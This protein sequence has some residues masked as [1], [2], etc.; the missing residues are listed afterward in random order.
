M[1]VYAS[2]TSYFS[3]RICMAACPPLHLPDATCPVPQVRGYED[4]LVRTESGGDL[5]TSVHFDISP[6]L[7]AA[8]LL[9]AALRCNA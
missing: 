1:D 9:P 8:L 5:C 3:S 6:L 2:W 4:V 7:E